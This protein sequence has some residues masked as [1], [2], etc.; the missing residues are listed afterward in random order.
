MIRRSGNVDPVAGE[1]IAELVALGTCRSAV[2]VERTA[3]TNTMALDELAAGGIPDSDLP[4]LFV[5]DAQVAGRGRL[6][7]SWVS[8]DATLTFSLVLGGEP[9]SASRPD[10]G[11]LAA[12][13]GVARAIEFCFAPLRAHLKWPNDVYLGGGKVAGIL[14][15]SNQLA[16][17]RRVVGIGLN[18]AA[19]PACGELKGAAP[20]AAIAAS[21]GRPVHRYEW[22]V[23]LVAHVVEAAGEAQSD[24][25]GI[26]EAFRAR[27]LL[28][29][30][31]VRTHR[32]NEELIGRCLGVDDRGHLVLETERDTAVVHSGEATLT[33][34]R[35]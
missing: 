3:S 19:A 8:S 12:G 4:K 32:G 21:V 30:R 17:D 10:L 20:V 34:S 1:A 25:R 6:G 11:S 15:E 23:D 35:I 28:T 7:R 26:L 9:R 16:A 18:V 5:A 27:C 33:R 13:V 2:H 29:G 24:P 31:E 22:F 14:C